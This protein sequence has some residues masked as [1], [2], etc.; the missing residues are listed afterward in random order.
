MGNKSNISWTDATW[1]P[2]YGCARV[3]DGCKNCYAEQ[4]VAGLARKFKGFNPE[5]AAFLYKQDSDTRSGQRPYLGE[6]DGKAYR[7]HQFPGAMTEP[8][9]VAL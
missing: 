2:L 6:L 5:V 9:E 7:W 1:N 3:S 4:V 8:E